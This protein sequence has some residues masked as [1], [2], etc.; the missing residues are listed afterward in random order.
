MIEIR[1]AKNVYNKD[2]FYILNNGKILIDLKCYQYGFYSLHEV[3]DVINSEIKWVIATNYVDI[4]KLKE[5]NNFNKVI[6]FYTFDD[7]KRIEDL[8]PELF[9]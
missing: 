3:V 6:T 1:K 7:L 2:V 4:A 8:H 5:Q 9:I